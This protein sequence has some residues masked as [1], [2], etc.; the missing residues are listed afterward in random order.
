MVTFSY[1]GVD[2]NDENLTN[3]RRRKP[4][5]GPLMKFLNKQ[6][7]SDEQAT[8]VMYAIAIGAFLL[9]LFFWF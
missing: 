8:R 6:G 3:K 5:K 2:L 1:M 9:S 4:Q 7:F